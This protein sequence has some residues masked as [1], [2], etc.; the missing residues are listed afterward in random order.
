MWH[1]DTDGSISDVG[2]ARACIPILRSAA[3][4]CGARCRIGRCGNHQVVF[5]T[6]RLKA[7]LEGYMPVEIDST[8][9]ACSRP[10]N[11]DGTANG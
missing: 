3:S 6:G 1:P 9:I 8:V 11:G 2:L 10:P 7:R 4:R 5:R